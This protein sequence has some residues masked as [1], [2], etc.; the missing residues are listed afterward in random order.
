MVTQV[1]WHVLASS[2]THPMWPRQVTPVP[3]GDG[4]GPDTRPPAVSQRRGWYLSLA[5]EP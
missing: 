5:D 1:R 2:P 3:A 4:I